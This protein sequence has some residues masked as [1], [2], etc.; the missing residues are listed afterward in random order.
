LF[1]KRF[2]GRVKS[3]DD[4]VTGKVV[5]GGGELIGSNHPTWNAYAAR[6]GLPFSDAVDEANP[7]V[8][9]KGRK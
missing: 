5:E 3:L 7:P 6:F 4:V 8:V 9:F 2:G 1:P